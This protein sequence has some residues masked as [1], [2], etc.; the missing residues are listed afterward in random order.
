ML[1]TISTI[2]DFLFCFVLFL[3]VTYKKKQISEAERKILLLNKRTETKN[4]SFRKSMILK[5]NN[6]VHHQ[7]IDKKEK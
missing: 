4:E 1:Q 7:K 6:K 5:N 3:L 2:D